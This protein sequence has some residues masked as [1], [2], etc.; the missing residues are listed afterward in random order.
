MNTMR[1]TTMTAVTNYNININNR[2]L[3]RTNL[4]VDLFV[5]QNIN[6]ID[7][8]LINYDQLRLKM[9]LTISKSLVPDSCWIKTHNYSLIIKSNNS[10]ELVV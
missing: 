2:K 5:I 1:G 7:L 10:N 8:K 6:G 3:I 4:I 9:K